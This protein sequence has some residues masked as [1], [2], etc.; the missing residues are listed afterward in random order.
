MPTTIR[1]TTKNDAPK[2]LELLKS[3][4][5]EDY[6]DK[7]VY[8]PAWIA[9]QLDPAGGHE[10]WVA[11]QGGK[12][13]ASV[14]I[15]QPAPANVN[16][17]VNL[18]RNLFIAESFADGSADALLAKIKGVCHERKQLAVTRV[19]A[20]DNPQQIAFENAG[21]ICSGFQPYKHMHR[22][23]QGVLFYTLHGPAVITNRLPLSESLAPVNELA[24]VVLRYLNIT[25][26]MMVRDGVTGYPLQTEMQIHDA[27]F[28]DFD[29]WRLQ[30]QAANPPVEVSGGFNLGMG[31][32]RTTSTEPLRAVLGQ[33]NNNIVA[34]LAYLFDDKDRC[35]RIIDSFSQD[36]LSMG[37]LFHHAV[38][39]AQGQFNAIY[40]EV[41]VLMTAPR[42]LKAA[43]QLGFVPV[44]YLPALYYKAGTHTDVVKLVKLNMIYSPEESTMT[45]QAKA[46]VEAV[47]SN[48]QDQKMGV[49]II[50]LLRALPVFDGLG[51]GEL[52]K[53]SRLFTQKLYRPGEKIFKKGDS[54]SEAYVV[55]RGQIDICL[56]EGA[57]PLASISNGQIFGELAFLDGAARTAMA[58]AAQPSILL[59]IQ[60]SAFYELVQR[61][62]HL[63]MV[64]MRNIGMILSDRLR[65][66][67]GGPKK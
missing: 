23:R 10:T 50:N 47:S 37:S 22:V 11:E 35:M 24:T 42:L 41:D 20:P 2:W 66:A 18:G 9:S 49:A 17:V 32:L 33:R 7:S 61:E 3:T 29:L 28:E 34:G 63:G 44:A 27:T 52:R 5:G 16:P 14:A 57:K 60:R 25:N 4:L 53:I 43:E 8:D 21:F 36:D 64:I 1:Q 12:F 31:L 6:V 19:L 15:L 58:L 67:S 40:L 51:D 39:L 45:S 56:E 30:A 38:K 13:K 65:K 48:Y 62:P 59:V 46:V 54:G 55:M 26:M